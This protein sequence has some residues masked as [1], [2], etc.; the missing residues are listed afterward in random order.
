MLFRRKGG[1]NSALRHGSCEF[2]SGKKQA[3]EVTLGVVCVSIW[4]TLSENQNI[5]KEFADKELKKK[6]KDLKYCSILNLTHWR[7]PKM[8]QINPTP[9]L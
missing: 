5:I 6:A 9:P 4:V 8:D 2:N 7:N 1:W 3:A